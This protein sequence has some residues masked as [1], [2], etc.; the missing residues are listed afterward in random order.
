LR[1]ADDTQRDRAQHGPV[2]KVAYLIVDLAN[3]YADAAD[4]IVLLPT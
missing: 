2:W 4:A 3:Y 1:R